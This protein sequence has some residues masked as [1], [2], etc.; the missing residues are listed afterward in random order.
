M[1]FEDALKVAIQPRQ[2]SGEARKAQVYRTMED[3]DATLSI[4]RLNS[5]EEV[6]RQFHVQRVKRY[7][8]WTASRGPKFPW[9][10][11]LHGTRSGWDMTVEELH[12]EINGSSTVRYRLSNLSEI[13]TRW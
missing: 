6:L 10:G 5:D 4:L 12:A 8:R 13:E 7:C 9:L 3:G 2:Q 1:V 11:T